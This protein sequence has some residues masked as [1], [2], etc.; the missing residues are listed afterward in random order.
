M[1]KIKINLGGWG[2]VFAIP[3]QVVDDGLKYADGVKL[4]ILLYLLR[5]AGEERRIELGEISKATGVNVTDIP[6]AIDY[7]VSK[8]LLIQH[9]PNIQNRKENKHTET[10]TSLNCSQHSCSS[11]KRSVLPILAQ[12]LQNTLNRPLNKEDLSIIALLVD[13]FE[14]KSEVILM[15]FQY[16][17]SI[18][19]NNIHTIERIGAEWAKE[20]IDTVEKADA[21]I[22]HI[23]S[24]DKDYKVVSKIFGIANT[25]YPT[26]KQLEF[27][28]KWVRDWGFNEGML[29]EACERCIK[30]KGEIKFNYIDG[31]L[32]N[33]HTMGLCEPNEIPET[34]Q[35]TNYTY[36]S[37]QRKTSYDIREIEKIDTL[38]FID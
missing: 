28:S 30:V 25:S 8:G 34:S 7:W 24:T 13:V 35:Q 26:K 21:K 19:K 36:S 1:Q 20:G 3:T 14:M 16:C 27:C 11:G 31:I 33:W 22:N 32:K 15:L 18:G 9:E 37:M 5:Y 4:R 38:D 6:E 17:V 10:S 2:S 12:E 29:R 23:H